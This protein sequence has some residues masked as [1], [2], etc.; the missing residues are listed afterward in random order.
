MSKKITEIAKNFNMKPKALISYV[1]EQ[2]FNISENAR[3]LDD[4]TSELIIGELSSIVPTSEAQLNTAEI[5]DEII[6]Q[7]QEK[8]L[9]KAQRKKT[10]GKEKVKV[11]KIKEE[12]TEKEDIESKKQEEKTK[13]IEI[14]DSI[15][16][17]EFA[18]KSGINPAKVIGELMKNGI[19]ANIN[20]Q[21]DYDTIGIIALELGIKIRKK[22]AK[23]KIEDVISGNLAKLLKE[24]DQSLLIPRPPVVSIMGHVDHGK[25]KLLDY[26]RKTNV[27]AG[28]AGGITQHIGAYQVE[29]NGHKITFLDTPGHEAFTAMRARGARATDIAI[30]VVAADEGVKTQTLE[31]LNHA[32]DAGIPI[33]VAINKMDKENANPNKVKSE[34]AE[35]GLNPEDWGGD[36]IMVPISAMTGEGIDKLLDMISLTA[37]VQDLKAN[38]NRPAV[39]TVIEAHLDQNMGP[40][41]TILINTGTLKIMDN[42]IIGA[43]YGRIKRMQDYKRQKLKILIPSDTAQIAGLSSTPHS[44]DI[45][46]V[47]SSEKEARHKAIAISDILKLKNIFSQSLSLKDLVG[48]I[49][50]G[51]L[52]SLKLIIKADA[53]GSLEAIK[54]SLTKLPSEKVTLKIVH[55]GIGNVTESD[56]M[57]AAASGAIILGFHTEANSN[58][59]RIAE[60]QNVEMLFYKIIYKLIED[61][62]NLL[63]GLLDSE[64]VEVEIGKMNVLQIFFTKKNEAIIGGKII[65]GKFENKAKLKVERNAEIIGEGEINSLQKG[66][67]KEQEVKSGNECGI[68]FV[69]NVQIKEGDILIA[70]KKETKTKTL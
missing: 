47:V 42:V 44:G 34:L 70:T 41:A 30:L 23:A 1:R 17:K 45:L 60:R 9:I 7:E 54:Q 32:K 49:K 28:E 58:V 29:K 67:K 43:S 12:K 35:H 3:V 31:A 11:K 50:T 61:V 68:K 19:L 26:I 22:R 14:E 21:I 8:E 56:V 15:S 2:G 48:Q 38:P 4:E 62:T 51:N 25:T 24:D 18:E 5:Y 69:G 33:I 13:I 64:V 27:V 53:Q 66:D 36:T 63:T 6:H 16:I 37:E 10:A 57:M 65:S 46:Q 55:S 59:I 40:V 20:Q 39:G 52:K